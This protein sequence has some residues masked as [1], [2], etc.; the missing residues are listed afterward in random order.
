[1]PPIRRCSRGQYARCPDFTCA[2]PSAPVSEQLIGSG[3]GDQLSPGSGQRPQQI[4]NER[5]HRPA[6]AAAAAP[7]HCQSIAHRGNVRTLPTLNPNPLMQSN[8]MD[9]G[10]SLTRA[11]APTSVRRSAKYEQLRRLGAGA[12]GVVYQCQNKEN[13]EIV[14]IKYIKIR[15]AGD[16]IPQWALREISLLRRCS[17][18][19]PNIISLLDM[20]YYCTGGREKDCHIHLV[21]EFC[22]MDL[23][24]FIR[25]RASQSRHPG[26]TPGLVKDILYQILKG[27][28]F[29]HTMAVAHRDI[30]P[31]NILI[32]NAVVKI[33]DFGLGKVMM[34]RKPVSLEV[35]TLHYRPPEVLLSANY[36]FAV[37]IWSVGC[38]FAEM[39]N[40]EVL[41]A[42]E[43][44]ISQLKSIFSVL[45]LPMKADWPANCSLGLEAFAAM[46]PSSMATL[47]KFV[48]FVGFQGVDLMK[49]MLLFNP[50]KRIT[51]H[52]ALVHAY[53][54]RHISTVTYPSIV[55]PPRPA[56]PSNDTAD[57]LLFHSNFPVGG[58][59]ALPVA[60]TS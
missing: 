36:S 28:D 3:D 18:R 1:M 38:M 24:K 27:L 43:S 30:K 29:L 52:D 15:D 41:L 10:H 4:V 32:K 35:V 45:G 2:D 16:G 60:G 50:T 20:N 26:L 56:A 51:S 11:T 25:S 40:N 53:F 55:P 34:D 19:H 31:Q 17:S 57:K 22:D 49:N 59:V 58:G 7:Y 46:P 6:A 21:L 14:A 13:H 9:N 8:K 37:D 23:K 5:S 33:A 44:E 39:C 12:F 54:E 48:P 42:G 47:D